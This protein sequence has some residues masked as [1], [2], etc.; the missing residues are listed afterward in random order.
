MI[1]LVDNGLIL[2]ELK[3][4]QKVIE[5]LSVHKYSNNQSAYINISLKNL[6][7]NKQAT[8]FILE[9]DEYTSSNS[10]IK[11]VVVDKKG[12]N[13]VDTFNFGDDLIQIDDGCEKVEVRV[14]EVDYVDFIYRQN[15]LIVPGKQN[16]NISLEI[17]EY[18]PLK[19]KQY[20]PTYTLLTHLLVT[21]LIVGL[22]ILIHVI[23]GTR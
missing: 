6:L 16:E 4:G 22:V 23:G 3:N 14:I 9:V 13:F 7:A 17:G 1:N 12:S 15:G 19:K 5:I 2:F 8:S 11:T 10:F 20:V 21:F 18:Q